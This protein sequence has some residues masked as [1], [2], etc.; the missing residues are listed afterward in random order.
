M[1]TKAVPTS[2]LRSWSLRWPLVVRR[3]LRRR[4]LGSA[5]SSRCARNVC[6]SRCAGASC[7]STSAALSTN[8]PTARTTRAPSQ[9]S[10]SR[11]SGGQCSQ[12]AAALLSRTG[13]RINPFFET[14]FNCIAT[15]THS[16]DLPL[17]VDTLNGRKWAQR[18]S[19]I[20]ST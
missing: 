15:R 13:S 6:C 2:C 12:A 5:A 3:R 7:P 14:T 9:C 16:S 10:R 19:P 1:A 8:S 20:S 4:L 11:S 18:S 17:P